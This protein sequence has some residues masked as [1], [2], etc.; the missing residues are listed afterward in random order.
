MQCS[1]AVL[2]LSGVCQTMGHEE[3]SN[4]ADFEREAMEL[5][6]EYPDLVISTDGNAILVEVP[7]SPNNRSFRFEDSRM[8]RFLLLNLDGFKSVKVL[9]NKACI[10]VEG[11]FFG[12]LGF[13]SG[14]VPFHLHRDKP[15]D[16]FHPKESFKVR[17]VLH[18]FG[19]LGY[20][21]PFLR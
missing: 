9:G 5:S 3:N 11:R 8:L 20:L 13:P 2:A 12:L 15:F 21:V 1:A 18:P 14:R 6:N 17:I 7:E 10:M 19:I 16:F 4:G